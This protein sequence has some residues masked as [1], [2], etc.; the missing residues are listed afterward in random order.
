[1]HLTQPERAA[2]IK[3]LSDLVFI[4]KIIKNPQKN[5]R[6]ENNYSF[7]LSEKVSTSLQGS[8]LLEFRKLETRL[9]TQLVSQLASQLAD[10]TIGTHE[11]II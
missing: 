7:H 10:L 11:E 3:V 8:A 1:M 9:I 2:R 6:I 4:L 5:D